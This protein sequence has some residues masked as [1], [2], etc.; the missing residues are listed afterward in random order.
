MLLRSVFPTFFN[1]RVIL[2]CTPILSNNPSF[3][4][5]FLYLIFLI[6]TRYDQLKA[7]IIQLTNTC[8]AQDIQQ[9]KNKNYR[10]NPEFD[11]IFMENNQDYSTYSTYGNTSINENSHNTSHQ[12]QSLNQSYNQG[13]GHNYNYNQNQKLNQ[14]NT[15]FS[16]DSLSKTLLSSHTRIHP[17]HTQNPKLKLK[18][19]VRTRPL[20]LRVVAIHILAGLRLVRILFSIRNNLENSK[21]NQNSIGVRK[22]IKKV[23][24]TVYQQSLALKFGRK[25]DPNL[26]N[27]S[28]LDLISSRSS[29]RSGPG[30]E[31]NSNIH[32]TQRK[33]DYDNG[34]GGRDG[35]R[36]SSVE[37]DRESGVNGGQDGTYNAEY[38]VDK[39]RMTICNMSEVIAGLRAK[40]LLLYVSSNSINQSLLLCLNFKILLITVNYFLSTTTHCF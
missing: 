23:P 33:S 15:S 13:Q 6:S 40:E 25:E 35:G 28:L 7:E 11:P 22:I 32:S 18:L 39:I 26:L 29:S 31:S 14:I 12:N 38:S 21:K 4:P 19:Y 24:L 37:R 27:Y 8:H 16:R 34:V 9:N 17:P 2:N 10:K 36:G 3:I 5:N 1:Q 20:T 30:S